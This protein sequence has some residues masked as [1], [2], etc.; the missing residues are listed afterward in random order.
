MRKLFPL[1]L[2]LLAACARFQPTT[3]ATNYG[4]SGMAQSVTLKDTSVH[5]DPAVLRVGTPRSRV[6]AAFGAA[7]ASETTPTGQIEDVYAFN[8]DGTKFADPQIRPRNIALAVFSMGTS[9]AVRQ[10]RLAMA[11]RKLTL[12]HVSYGSDGTV[13]SVREE[14]MSAAPEGG[15]SAQP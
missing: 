8:P 10:A 6:Q 5:Y 7:N 12:Y 9:I 14:K 11:E 13:Q 3:V 1:A 15:P 2:T 4:P